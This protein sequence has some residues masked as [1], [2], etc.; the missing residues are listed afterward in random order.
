MK[1]TIRVPATTANLGPGFDSLGLALSLW[2]EAE[3]ERRDRG[4]GLTVSIEGFGAESY[5]S[6]PENLV[7]QAARH[8]IEAAGA[9]ALPLHFHCR[10]AIPGGSGLGSSS[11]AILMGLAGAN[12]FLGQ[13]FDVQGL[14]DLAN[15]IEGHPDNVTPGVLG[16]LTLSAVHEGS[17]LARKVAP[18]PDWR[19]GVVVPEMAIQTAAMRAALPEQVPLAAAVSNLS[20]AVLVVQAFVQGDLPLLR[21]VMVDRL[22]QP[23]RLPLIPG[24]AAAIEAAHLL[25]L[26]AALSGAGPGVAVFGFDEGLLEEATGRMARV[27]EAGGAAAWCWVGRVDLQGLQVF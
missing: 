14:L 26:P 16:G 11:S 20:R 7:L 5:P 24:A 25:G 8:L 12:A 19:V 10:N 3:V 4:G 22:H 27:F 9:P 17:V 1:K 2:N 23:H 6:G 21:D 13:P 18:A 15:R